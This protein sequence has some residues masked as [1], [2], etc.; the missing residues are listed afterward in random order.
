[1]WSGRFRQSPL[2][3]GFSELWRRSFEFDKRLLGSR[4]WRRGNGAHARA[5]KDAAVCFPRPRIDFHSSR[6]GA[7]RREGRVCGI[8]PRRD[9]S[10]GC[11]S[12]CREAASRADRRSRIQ[13]A[14]RPQPQRTDC[15]RS[16]SLHSGR[17]RS[18]ASRSARA[19]RRL[20]SLCRKGRRGGYA[21]L[22]SL[23]NRPSLCLLA[24]GCWPTS[25]CFCATWIAWP[26]AA[27][28]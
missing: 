10:G 1:M 13:A 9:G 3:P 23:Y 25:R 19:A 21:G 15:H 12:L 5:L 4:S 26:I 22:H 16:S 17:H 11:A 18:A 24:I 14:Q 2:D 27:S 20:R 7:D 8:S 6:I 28:G